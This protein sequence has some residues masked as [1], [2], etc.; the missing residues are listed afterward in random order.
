MSDPCLFFKTE[1]AFITYVND[2]IFVIKNERLID[3]C[4]ALLRQRGLELVEE[5]GYTRDLCIDLQQK[6]D[7]SIHMLQT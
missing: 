3:E 7:R 4:I 6:P 5:D 2:G 1:I